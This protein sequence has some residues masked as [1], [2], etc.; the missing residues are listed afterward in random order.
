MLS[1]KPNESLTSFNTRM[2]EIRQRLNSCATKDPYE[3]SRPG[4]SDLDCRDKLL[5]EAEKNEGLRASALLWKQITPGKDKTYEHLKHKLLE[6]ET[7]N[8]VKGRSNSVN[9]VQYSNHN[10]NYT[11][12][13]NGKTPFFTN[14]GSYSNTQNSNNKISFTPREPCRNWNLGQGECKYGESCRFIHFTPPGGENKRSRPAESSKGN[15]NKEICNNFLKGRCRFA[16]KCH[17]QHPKTPYSTTS[18][19][20]RQNRNKKN[21]TSHS[22]SNVSKAEEKESDQ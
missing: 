8:N 13:S 20:T 4:I 21:K 7:S 1:M 3:A 19:V 2:N 9:S 22:V 17:R 16:N 5:S 10:R 15:L 6:E 18:I 14:S 12:N 11:N